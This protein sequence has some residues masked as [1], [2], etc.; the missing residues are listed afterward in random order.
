MSSVSKQPPNYHLI[1]HWTVPSICCL[2]TNSPRVEYIHCPFRSARLWRNTF[3]RLSIKVTS[4]HPLRQQCQVS[5]L[6]VRRTGAWGPAL[7]TE[8]WI[9]RQSSSPSSFPLVPAAL[10]ELRGARIFS[11]LDLWSAYKLVRI[12]EGDE[13]KMAFITP[14][15]HYEYFVMPF[16]LTNNY[17]LFCLILEFCLPG[18]H[19]RDV[20]GVPP[21][22]CDSL[23]WQHFHLLSEPGRPAAICQAGP[24]E[25]PTVSSLPEAREMWAP[26]SSSSA[27]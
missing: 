23:Y 4:I 18:I 8:H 22:L 12:R 1:G 6:W 11:K 14:S 27:M 3:R 10:E 21:S 19:E 15:G 13:W 5:S 24:S 26:P 9:Y 20:P 2:D 25:A 7:I 16:G 17:W